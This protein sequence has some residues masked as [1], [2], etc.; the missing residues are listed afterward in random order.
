MIAGWYLP[1]Q[2]QQK[3]QQGRQHIAS[4]VEAAPISRTVQH[5]IVSGVHFSRSGVKML[6]GTGTMG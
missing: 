3:Q 2:P 4:A 1:K 6:R 5:V